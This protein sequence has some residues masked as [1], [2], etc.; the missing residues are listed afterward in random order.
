LLWRSRALTPKVCKS[1]IGILFQVCLTVPLCQ[2]LYH[3]P[4]PHFWMS[5]N[6]GKPGLLWLS[7]ALTPQ[8]CK[9]DKGILSYVYLTEPLCQILYHTHPT[10]SWM[11]GNRG[12]LGLLWVSRALTPQVCKSDIGILPQV[13][14]TEPL[15][16][17]LY[18]IPPPH[19]WMSW[20]REKHG[21]LWLSRALRPKVCK[22]DIGILP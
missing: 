7:S 22:S 5:W 4:P 20:N 1:D 11:G 13:Y 2:I 14:L 19:F 9:S 21:L 15:C 6:R 3:I 16:Q 18:H 10:H 17:I 12:K 8:V